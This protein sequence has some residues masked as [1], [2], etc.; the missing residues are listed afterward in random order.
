MRLNDAPDVSKH[1][2]VGPGFFEFTQLYL[3]PLRDEL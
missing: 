1:H 2:K 3:L